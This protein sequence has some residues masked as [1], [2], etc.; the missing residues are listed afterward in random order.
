[1]CVKYMKTNTFQLIRQKFFRRDYCFENLKAKVGAFQ[2]KG[3]V[4]SEMTYCILLKKMKFHQR[5]TILI[6]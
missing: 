1:M 6:I 2:P 5:C 3:R 4:V